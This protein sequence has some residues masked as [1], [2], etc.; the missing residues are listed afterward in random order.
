MFLDELTSWNNVK[1]GECVLFLMV[2]LP[3]Y[4]YDGRIWKK[5]MNIEGRPFLSHP[6]KLGLMLNCDWFQPF[7]LSMYSV[8]V[9]YLVIFFNLPRSIR[10]KPENVLIA[11][12]IPGPKEPR[13]SEINSYLKPLVK[14]L[15]SLQSD[16]FIMQH[17]DVNIHAALLTTVCD[18]PAT[19]KLGGFMGHS[20]SHACCKSSKFFPYSKELNCVD[21]SWDIYKHMMSTRKCSPNTICNY[22]NTAA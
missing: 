7:N 12:I 5:F 10:F 17:K 14:E 11:G 13:T 4:V 8:G 6:Y 9:L 16:G 22:S 2:L 20:S 21:F 1:S 3:T 15:N 19:A 18:I